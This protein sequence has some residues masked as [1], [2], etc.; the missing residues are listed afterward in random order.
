MAYDRGEHCWLSYLHE[1]LCRPSLAERRPTFGLCFRFII[2]FR[3]L[4]VEP[5]QWTDLST[6]GNLN[7]FS[8]QES[9]SKLDGGPSTDIG[10]KHECNWKLASNRNVSCRNSLRRPIYIVNSD[11]KT[12]LSCPTD[13]A[14]HFFKNLPHLIYSNNFDFNNFQNSWSRMM[15][16]FIISSKEALEKM[17]IQQ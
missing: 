2:R 4:F 12:K 5:F 11:D 7:F 6:K 3:L 1:R 14:P 8:M 13:E 16:N 10:E 15:T 17:Q 9:F